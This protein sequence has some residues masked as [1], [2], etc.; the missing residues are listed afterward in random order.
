MIGK[1]I[2]LKVHNYISAHKTGIL[3]VAGGFGTVANV[4]PFPWKLIPGGIALAL[5]AVAGGYHLAA[6][7]TAPTP[8]ALAAPDILACPPRKPE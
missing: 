5:T 6:A 1:L 7:L 3:A 4:V 8:A 2:A